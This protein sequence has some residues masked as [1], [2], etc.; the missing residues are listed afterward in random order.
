M[1]GQQNIY[2]L[3]LHKYLYEMLKESYPIHRNIITRVGHYIVTESDLREF[4]N[5][6][7]EIF[8]KAYTK[9]LRDYHDQLEAAGIKVAIS[10]NK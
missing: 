7:A 4:S 3:A 8:E 2:E 9:A 5:L 10:Y 1:F 6:V